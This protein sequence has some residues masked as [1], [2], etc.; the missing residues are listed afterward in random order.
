MKKRRLMLLFSLLLGLALAC[1]LGASQKPAPTGQYYC[2]AWEYGLITTYPVFTISPGG[3]VSV[4]AAESQEGDWTFDAGKNSFT[5][6]GAVSL[7]KADFDADN[8]RWVVT[9]LPDF[10]DDYIS[11]QFVDADQGLLRCYLAYPDNP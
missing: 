4:S 7:Q 6:S 5:F 10:Q 11:L 2:D 8:S 9:I 3:K 1:N